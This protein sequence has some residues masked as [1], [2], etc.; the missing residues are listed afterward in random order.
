MK[1]VWMLDEG[2]SAKTARLGRWW[3]NYVQPYKDMWNA[4]I[5]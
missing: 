5:T 2:S 1:L 3:Q 4:N